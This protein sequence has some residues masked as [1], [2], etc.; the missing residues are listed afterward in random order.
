MNTNDFKIKYGLNGPLS[1]L[2][3]EN[4]HQQKIAES[5]IAENR[6]KRRNWMQQKQVY[7]YEPTEIISPITG[8]NGNKENIDSD[9]Q[10]DFS[11]VN[12]IYSIRPQSL[13]RTTKTYSSIEEYVN[14]QVQQEIINRKIQKYQDFSIYVEERNMTRNVNPIPLDFINRKSDNSVNLATND[15]HYDDTS[16][17]RTQSYVNRFNDIHQRASKFYDQQQVTEK[18]CIITNLTAEKQK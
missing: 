16:Y 17:I 15:V 14:E 10:K 4:S 9:K 1:K 3:E 11:L 12:N 2:Y 6:R 7:G 18:K 8:S 13:V 5:K